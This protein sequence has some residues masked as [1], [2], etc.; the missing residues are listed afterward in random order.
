MTE[1]G[2]IEGV[3]VRPLKT[4][5]DQ[6]GFVRHFMKSKDLS[7]GRS[8]G[9]VYFSAVYPGAVKAWHLHRIAWLN[10]VCVRGVVTVGLYDDRTGSSTRGNDMVIYLGDDD[11]NYKLVTIP[12]FVW[13]GYRTP[14][15]SRDVAMIA[16]LMTDQYHS[17]NEIVRMHPDDADFEFD[18]GPYEIAG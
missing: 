3:E 15:Y 8:F 1:F 9:E 16:N 6:R 17:E 13:N 12:P 5:A 11:T 14:P 10:Y 7:T 4:I 18:W 2:R